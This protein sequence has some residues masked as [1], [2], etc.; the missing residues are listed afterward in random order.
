MAT[1]EEDKRRLPTADRCPAWVT[2][3]ASPREPMR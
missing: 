1:I 3:S 2:D